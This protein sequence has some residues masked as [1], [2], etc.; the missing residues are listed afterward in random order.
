MKFL[1]GFGLI[2]LTAWSVIARNPHDTNE[3]TIKGWLSDAQCSRARAEIGLYT[4]TN[5]EC[6]KRCVREG[7]KVVL[8]IPERKEIIVVANPDLVKANVGDL[9][10]VVGNVGAD[11]AFHVSTVKILEKG[12][13]MCDVPS[14]KSKSVK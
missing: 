9:V 5:P 3:T 6:A 11:H 13:A 14:S 8:I 4:G 2:L 12:R 7:K 1:P 10:E